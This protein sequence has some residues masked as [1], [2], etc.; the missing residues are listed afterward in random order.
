M[1][2]GHVEAGNFLSFERIDLAEL[3]PRLNVVAGPNGAGKT[4]LIRALKMV[5]DAP[6][7]RARVAWERATRVGSQ[8]QPCA[9]RIEL[10]LNDEW[11]K[12]FLT[13]F[14]QA[15]LVSQPGFSETIIDSYLEWVKTV[16]PTAIQ[17]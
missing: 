4:N 9:V 15:A 5:C 11:E 17:G 6:D 12:Q 2:I 7:V 10:E 14:I 1:R 16:S 13:S 8:D 3:D